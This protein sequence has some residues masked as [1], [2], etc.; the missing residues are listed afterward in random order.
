MELVLW[1]CA[2]QDVSSTIHKLEKIMP[3]WE[4]KDN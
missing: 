2:D 4:L 1:L 3:Q